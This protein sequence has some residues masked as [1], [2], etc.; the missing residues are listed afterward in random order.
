M[1]TGTRS[2]SR[3]IPEDWEDDFLD[4]DRWEN[5][6]GSSIRTRNDCGHDRK[7]NI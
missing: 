2:G 5:D 6:G 4:I 1:G 3:G 7:S